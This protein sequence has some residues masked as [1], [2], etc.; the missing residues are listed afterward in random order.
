MSF[1]AERSGVEESKNSSAEQMEALDSS[2]ALRMT[3]WA[4]HPEPVEGRTPPHLAARRA[5]MDSA[6]RTVESSNSGRGGGTADALRSG[7]SAPSGRESSNLSL[8]TTTDWTKCGRKWPHVTRACSSVW[9]ER[10]P[11]EAE[12][13][14]SSPAKR[15]TSSTYGRLAQPVRASALHAEGRGFEPLAAHHPGDNQEPLI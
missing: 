7:R 9:I 11:A 5:I 15:A 13:V 6:Q 3:E 14:G 12:A 2:A 1:R 8:G 4:V 10:S